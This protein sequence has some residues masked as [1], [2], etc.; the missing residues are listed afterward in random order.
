M[1]VIN[2]ISIIAMPLVILIIISRAL[3]EKIPI[4]EFYGINLYFI[5]P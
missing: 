3:K 4:F 1:K 5:I 2:Y